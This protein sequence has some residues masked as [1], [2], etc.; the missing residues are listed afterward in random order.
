VTGVYLF[1]ALVGGTLAAVITFGGGD[2]DADVDFDAD[3][4]LDLDASGVGAG[5]IGATAGS[6]LAS[7]FSFRTLVFASAFFGI[8]G[9]IVPL[10]GAGT[11]TTLVLALGVGGLAGFVNDR[12]LR[13]LRRTSGDARITED[14]LVGARAR[15]AVPVGAGR[16]GRVM[17]DIDGRTVGMVAEAYRDLRESFAQDDQVVVVEVKDGVARI[18]PMDDIE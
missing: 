2:A 13:F 16:R 12:L 17:V 15:V 3:V 9:L 5:E 14:H 8:T 7:I 10:V 11:V 6:A 18:A 1:F 4:D